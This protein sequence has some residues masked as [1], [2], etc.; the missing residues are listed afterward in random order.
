MLKASVPGPYTLSGRLIPGGPY[1][2]RFAVAEGLLPLVR[3]ELERLVAAGCQEL[4]VDEPSMSCYA[5]R[6]DRQRSG[7]HVQSNDGGPCAVNVGY[8]HIS[9]L[10]TTR[11][12]RW[13]LDVTRRFF[14][15]SF[16]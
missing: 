3:R 5:Y 16:S 6:E 14:P 4:T 12:E 11:G 7:G 10:A 1:A 8:R 13:G 15:I 2:D 9:V